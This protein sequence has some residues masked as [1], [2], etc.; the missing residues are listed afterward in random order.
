MTA[1]GLVVDKPSAMTSHDVV[2]RV[3]RA[4]GTRQVG[5]AGTLDPMATG[6]LVVLVG[7]ATKLSSYVTLDDKAYETTIALGRETTS[8][9]RDGETTRERGVPDDLVAELVRAATGAECGRIAE[10]LSAERRRTSQVPPVVSAIHVGGKR[11]HELARAGEAVELAARSIRVDELVLLGADPETRTLRLRVTASK[12]Y[13]VR[14]LARDLG[15]ALGTGAHLVA[16]RRIASGR[17]SLADAIGIDD[18]ASRVDARLD[19]ADVARRTFGVETLTADGE[20]RAR[21][22][23]AL[24]AEH[25]VSSAAAGARLWLSPAGMP[26]AIGARAEDEC[27]RVLRGISS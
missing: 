22:G 24:G 17:F 4:L 16:L 18:I 19:I 15:D 7:E 14:A 26:V 11:S 27:W 12:G 1:F 8:H 25:F 5:H 2:G 23:K 20:L 9:D 13:Y 21:V 3:R 6:V 10:A